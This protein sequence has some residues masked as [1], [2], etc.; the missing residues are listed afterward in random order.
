MTLLGVGMGW[1]HLRLRKFFSAR[2]ILLDPHQPNA[3]STVETY[4]RYI[5]RH[6]WPRWEAVRAIWKGLQSR[7]GNKRRSSQQ[8]SFHRAFARFRNAHGDRRHSPDY[9]GVG[10]IADMFG[11]TS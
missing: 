6:I 11:L 9:G 4:R 3:H 7:T 2:T 10:W 5:N 1:L 8:S